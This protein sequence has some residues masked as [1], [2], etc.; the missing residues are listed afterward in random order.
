VP[1]RRRGLVLEWEERYGNL[2]VR[3]DFRSALP[4]APINAISP[5]WE[6]VGCCRVLARNK[7]R[8][9]GAD[10]AR[11]AAPPQLGLL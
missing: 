10:G 4:G 1:E 3:M 11:L 8:E 7:Q 9:Q 2:S 6:G 5:V